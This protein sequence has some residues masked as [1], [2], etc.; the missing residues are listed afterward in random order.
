MLLRFF[1]ESIEDLSAPLVIRFLVGHEVCES[2]AAVRS[3]Q[4]ER[5]LTAVEEG[6]QEGSRDV[7]EIGGVLGG[8]LRVDRDDGD[9]VAVRH[10]SENLEE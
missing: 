3:D 6:H 5:N 1:S 4:A 8:Q 7:E 10:L 2:D 9:R